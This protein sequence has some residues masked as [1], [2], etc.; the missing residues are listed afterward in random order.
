MCHLYFAIFKR[1][2][3]LYYS[4]NI[5]ENPNESK[6]PFVFLISFDG[7]KFSSNI[8]RIFANSDPDFKFIKRMEI[9]QRNGRPPRV[10]YLI[11]DK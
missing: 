1:Q 6:F 8:N 4:F 10:L 9:K 3:D 11:M 2:V 5:S 7:E